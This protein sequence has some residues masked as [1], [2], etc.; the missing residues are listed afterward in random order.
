M[1]HARTPDRP[2]IL[3]SCPLDEFHLCQAMEQAIAQAASGPFIVR[4]VNR[5]DEAPTRPGDLGVA[6]YLDSRQSQGL[7]GHLEWQAGRDGARQS[8][9]RV[10]FSVVD[11]PLSSRM[12]GHFAEGLIRA[13]TKLQNTLAG[14]TGD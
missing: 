13:D 11:A 10:E 7:E 6:L 5:G 9:P 2:L 4:I 3:L 14:I 12:Y 8:G 1:A